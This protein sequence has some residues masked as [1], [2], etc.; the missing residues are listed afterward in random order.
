MKDPFHEQDMF[1]VKVGI[2][3]SAW[4]LFSVMIAAL[5]GVFS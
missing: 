1:I 3:L 5:A 4:I 2:G